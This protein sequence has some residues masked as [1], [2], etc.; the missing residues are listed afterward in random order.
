MS[1]GSLAFQQYQKLQVNRARQLEQMRGRLTELGDDYGLQ[2]LDT[3]MADFG[4][5]GPTS[6]DDPIGAFLTE[7]VQQT[8]DALADLGTS[9]AAL[10]GVWAVAL[11]RDAFSAR[12]TRFTDG[13][14]LV[15]VSDATFSLCQLYAQAMGLAGQL[16]SEPQVLAGLLRY[17]NT[18]QR[19]FGIA[20][21]LE[22]RLEPTA[23]QAAGL[24]HYLAA[25][26]VV[27]HE[28]AH[29]VL[30]HASSVSAFAP[31]EYLPVCAENH[32]LE[33]EA[34]L[35]ALRVVRRACEHLSDDLPPGGEEAALGAVGAAIG[36]LAV[37]VTE[38]ALFVRRGTSH[39]PAR[40]RAAALLREMN[41]EERR[42]AEESFGLALAATEAACSTGA[43]AVS[44]SAGMI[45][46]APIHTPLAPSYL[47]TIEVFDELQ[48][49]SPEWY[50]N[51]LDQAGRELGEPWLTDG[52]QL[53]AEGDSAAALRIWGVPKKNIGAL[54]DPQQPLTFYALL[55]KLQ[56]AFIAREIPGDRL[57]AYAIAAA[58]LVS[59]FLSGDTGQA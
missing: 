12:M 54:C 2:Q 45:G 7:L 28:L 15:A 16:G 8:K 44:F 1:G 30:G 52:A 41:S 51:L 42:F 24:F 22:I 6:P 39:P 40:Q 37:H 57:R 9:R 29:Y 11:K 38:Q 25:Q 31:D 19:V 59:E 20:G 32:Q 43:S 26:F 49:R 14:G 21:K 34:D 10:A 47:R 5:T 33:A 17:Y 36:M 35:H 3:M 56:T 50:L 13:S 4:A 48:C 27:A 58:M 53:A 55:M 46:S 18:Q 23:T